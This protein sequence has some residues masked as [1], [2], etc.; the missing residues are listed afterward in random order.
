[1]ISAAFHLARLYVSRHRFQSLLLAGSLGW[2]I[3]LPLV[4]HTLSKTAQQTMQQRAQST[5]QLLGAKGSA[6]DL[7][8]K[9]LYFKKHI[10]PTLPAQLV[11]E[12]RA[13]GLGDPIPLYI[14]F[15]AQ[16]SPIVA[17]DLD[18]FSFRHLGIAKGQMMSRLGDC[19]IGSRVASK[20]QLQPGDFVYST[21]E[22]VFDLAG[23]Y[24]LKMRIR[25]ILQS[26]GTPDDDAVFIDLKTARIIEGHAH[27][28]DDLFDTTV[29]AQEPGNVV[30]NASVRM[31]TEVTDQNLSGFHFHGDEST[32]PLSAILIVPKDAKSEAILAGRYS[33]RHP[34]VQIIRP[35]E[36]LNTLFSTLFQMQAFTMLL[37]AVLFLASIT[38]AALVFALSFRMRQREFTTLAEVGLPDRA[39]QLTK[40]FEILWITGGAASVALVLWGICQWQAETWVR[41]FLLR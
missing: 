19:I 10:L 12:V 5:P 23:V 3:A 21:Q 36:E 17:T 41:W 40:A 16:Q 1:M 33:S 15:Q 35:E 32:Y 39:L 25:G 26:N 7:L 38:I 4:I 28:H 31:Y 22:Q 8:L 14:R 30:G 34:S 24:P 27:G 13:T 18:Y 37:L 29:L 6:L 11:E 2:L 20:R 9:S